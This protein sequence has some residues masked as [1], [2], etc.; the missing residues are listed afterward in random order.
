[1]PLNLMIE[2]E[3]LLFIGPPEIIMNSKHALS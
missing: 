3:N 1:M 2:R